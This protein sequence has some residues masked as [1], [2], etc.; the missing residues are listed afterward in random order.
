MVSGDEYCNIDSK[1]TCDDRSSLSHCNASS[2]D[3]NTSR[4]INALHACIDSPC[5]SCVCSLNKSHDDMLVTPCCHDINASSSSSC[6]VC[7]NVE[8]TEDSI[9]QDNGLIR[10]SSNSPSSSIVS[11]ICL[12]DM[13]SKVTP[14]FE[15]TISSDDD[16]EDGDVASLI[17]KSEIMFHSIRKNKISCSYFYKI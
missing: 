4:N 14:T 2:L 16:N 11:H 10:T 1:I 7:N 9:G 12:T 13:Y 15:P 8:E 17:E 3:L 6:W 5:I